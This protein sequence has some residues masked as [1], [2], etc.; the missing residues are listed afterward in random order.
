MLKERYANVIL[1]NHSTLYTISFTE[2]LVRKTDAMLG[3]LH[4]T[5]IFQDRMYYRVHSSFKY[6]IVL[7]ATAFSRIDAL[8]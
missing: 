4:N 3:L 6:N 1:D 7:K 5:K 8:L 2:S